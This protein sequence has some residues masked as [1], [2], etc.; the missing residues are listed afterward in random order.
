MDIQRSTYFVAN[1]F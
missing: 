1:G